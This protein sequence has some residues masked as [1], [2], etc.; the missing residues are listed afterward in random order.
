MRARISGVK[1]LLRGGGETEGE[2]KKRERKRTELLIITLRGN[3]MIEAQNTW[4][5]EKKTERNH[6]MKHRLS[7]SA[8]K[9]FKFKMEYNIAEEAKKKRARK[10]D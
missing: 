5:E 2:N 10:E 7:S 4:R 9:T 8:R 6:K 3:A 1:V